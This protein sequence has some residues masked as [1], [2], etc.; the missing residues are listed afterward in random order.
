MSD[1]VKFTVTVSDFD[2]AAWAKENDVSDVDAA[3]AFVIVASGHLAD[4]LENQFDGIKVTTAREDGS[5]LFTE[6]EAELSE[7]DAQVVD[8]ITDAITGDAQTGD[9]TAAG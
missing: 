2:I 5:V 1:S 6:E 8:D 3:D 7:G 4:A 9:A